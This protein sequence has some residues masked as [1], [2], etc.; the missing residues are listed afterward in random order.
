[1]SPGLTDWVIRQIVDTPLKV[2]LDT[3]ACFATADLRA[4]LPSLRV[5][6]LI[7][8][9]DLDTSA[10]IE[11]TG[12]KTAALIP[13]SRL[14]VY[15]GSGHGLYAADHERVNGDILEFIHRREALAA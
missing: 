2:L 11:L 5:P 4:E 14:I 10:P 13:G 15:E 9:G 12:R 8:H 3:A 1:V 6:T 7:L